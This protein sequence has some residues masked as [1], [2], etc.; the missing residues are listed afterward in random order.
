[1]TQEEKA[2]QL[3]NNDYLTED[4]KELCPSEDTKIR[5][6]SYWASLKM[7]EWK[8]Q[9]MID[10]ACEWLEKNIAEATGIDSYTIIESFKQAMKEE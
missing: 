8:E 7:A 3:S 5:I 2:R 1:M 4:D 10:K 9:Q 6:N